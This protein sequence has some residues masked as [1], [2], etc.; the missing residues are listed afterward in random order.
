VAKDLSED[1]MR[2]VSQLRD[3]I[4]ETLYQIIK[5][6]RPDIKPTSQFGNFLLYLPTVTS[7][8][9][10]VG[11]NLRFAQTFSSHGAV[12]LITSLFG[13][14]PVEPFPEAN[15]DELE[16]HE[17]IL[18]DTA[19]QTDPKTPYV[20]RGYKRRMPASFTSPVENESPRREFQLL[21]APCSYTLAEMF[22]DRMRSNA[23][24]ETP[25]CEQEHLTWPL[26]RQSQNVSVTS[27]QPSVT[28]KRGNAPQTP[29]GQR[30]SFHTM[31]TEDAN[32]MPY[33]TTMPM[34]MQVTAQKYLS[35]PPQRPNYSPNIPVTITYNFYSPNTDQFHPPAIENLTFRHNTD[36]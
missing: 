4:H 17:I 33:Q 11:E 20:D 34:P 28:Q 12:P 8:A 36:N 13:C 2:K 26:R 24:Y 25:P 10:A 14:F 16:P 9:N 22:D 32:P 27:A 35:V 3:R 23:A 1:G 21:R 15:M 7:L 19:I 30:W 6:S 29:L 18:K 31:P 5:A